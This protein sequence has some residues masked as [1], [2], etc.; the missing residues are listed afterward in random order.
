[1]NSP[2]RVKWLTCQRKRWNRGIEKRR[3]NYRLR[4]FWKILWNWRVR[5]WDEILIRWEV[6]SWKWR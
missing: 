2:I 3:R 5:R 6:L 1:M 4:H